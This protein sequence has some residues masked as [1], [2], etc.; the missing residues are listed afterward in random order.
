MVYQDGQY[1]YHCIVNGK[2]KWYQGYEEI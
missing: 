1:K 2:F